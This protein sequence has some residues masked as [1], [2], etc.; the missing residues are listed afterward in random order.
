MLGGPDGPSSLIMSGLT[1]RPQAG[2]MAPDLI[3]IQQLM[4]IV[5]AADPAD[6]LGRLAPG[7]PARMLARQLRFDHAAILCFPT[8][9]AGSIAQLRERGGLAPARPMP[10]V[11][12]KQRLTE[13]ASSLPADADVQ[14]I[15]AV[16]PSGCQLEIFTLI[17]RSG[18]VPADLVADERTRNIETHFGFR[19][20]EPDELAILWR[21]LTGLA[22]LSPDGG[23]F[24]P[25]RAGGQTTLYF[26]NDGR[27]GTTPWPRR[28]ELIANGHHPEILRVHGISPTDRTAPGNAPTSAARAYS[29]AAEVSRVTSAGVIGRAG[30]GDDDPHRRMLALMTGAWT[31][32]AIHTAVRLGLAD[33]LQGEP[34]T[35]ATLADRTAANPDRLFRLLRYLHSVG[36]VTEAGD[37]A[38][39]VPDGAAGAAVRWRL[40]PLGA[41]LRTDNRGSLRDLALLYGGI[42]YQAFGNL[43][44]AITTGGTAFAATFGTE[45]FDYLAQHPDL[46]RLFDRGMAAGNSVFTHVPEAIDLSHARRIVDVGGGN[47]EL[48]SHLLG[49]APNARGTLVDVPHVIEAAGEHLT[50]RGIIDRCDLT[51]SDIT[52]RVPT[53]GDLYVLARILHDWDDLRCSAI[54]GAC[55]AAMPG[56]AQLA[57][58][59]RPFPD[60]SASDSLARLWDLHMMAC[61]GG[62][63]RTR[64]E[65][66]RLLGSAGFRLVDERP[67]PLDMSILLA[68]PATS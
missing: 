65:Y 54:L 30:T 1:S 23:G 7:P 64:A 8:S 28:L 20:D 33:H 60:D 63:E 58:I 40:T 43:P 34:L 13:R 42:F 49:A 16:L 15:H 66:R 5:G 27:L 21:I 3:R 26:R 68:Q 56:T 59:E 45:H 48:L 52:T 2:L 31:T 55:R 41:T 46:A 44:H 37:D 19:V 22:R 6:L 35:T 47:G 62:R 9:L 25:H 32:Q 29:P 12:V 50:A 24:N 14:I 17:C 57:I 38:D 39:A 51:A 61:V 10:S 53:G 18:V 36:I 4:D 11:I 67:L